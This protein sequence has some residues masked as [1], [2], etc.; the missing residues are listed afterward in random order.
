MGAACLPRPA[1]RKQ[2]RQRHSDDDLTR[3]AAFLG[4]A[5]TSPASRSSARRLAIAIASPIYREVIPSE[6][7]SDVQ[8]TLLLE[9]GWYVGK[10]GRLLVSK[11]LTAL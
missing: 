2:P 1:A 9:P 8:A 6:L 3:A 11:L 10:D 7:A 5:T 4:C